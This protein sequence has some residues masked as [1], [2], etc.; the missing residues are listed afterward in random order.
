MRIRD[1]NMINMVP[2]IFLVRHRTGVQS[3]LGHMILGITYDEPERRRAN[4]IG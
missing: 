4:W 2:N 3:I 1:A